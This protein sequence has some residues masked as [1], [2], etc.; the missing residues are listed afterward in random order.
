MEYQYSGNIQS[1][2]NIIW[3]NKSYTLTAVINVGDLC[4]FMIYRVLHLGPMF[5]LMVVRVPT[6]ISFSV[7][8]WLHHIQDHLAL[9]IL[10]TNNGV[11]LGLIYDW[12]P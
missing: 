7:I 8:W 1:L 11:K 3:A 4:Y 6:S 5:D 9:S 12:K 10:Y 2:Q